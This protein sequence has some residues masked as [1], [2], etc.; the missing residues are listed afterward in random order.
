MINDI[1]EF[2]KSNRNICIRCAFCIYMAITL[3]YL[4]EFLLNKRNFEFV[5]VASLV[6]WIPYGI[7]VVVSKST[8]M[9]KYFADIFIYGIVIFY[10]FIL[11]TR[12]SSLAWLYIIPFV[13]MTPF[14]FYRFGL[15]IAS[16]IIMFILNVIDVVIQLDYYIDNVGYVGLCI[17]VLVLISV[18]VLATILS[19]LLRK[20]E[21]I[22]NH[23]YIEASIDPLTNMHTSDF[24]NT[25]IAPMIDGNKNLNYTMLLVNLDKFSSINNLY[26]HSYGDSLLITVAN[27]IRQEILPIKSNTFLTRVYG[28]KFIVVFSNR[29]FEEVSD[30]CT[31]VK[32]HINSIIVKNSVKETSLSATVVVTDT[33]FC[34]HTFNGLY[35]RCLFLQD[36]LR[37]RGY[38]LYTADSFK[39]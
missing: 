30:Y 14:Y 3:V 20:Y 26:G 33:R 9:L 15:V 28:D 37:S 12:S 7:Q 8:S 11:F 35:K 4:T 24:I 18:F 22:I 32:T 36:M 10:T 1:D 29:T 38:N 25:K 39:F 5:L 17:R 13:F 6:M 34:E 27:I 31:S 23:I 21:G 19:V 16:Y 2:R